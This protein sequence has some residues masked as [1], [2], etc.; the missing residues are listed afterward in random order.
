MTTAGWI[1]M[2]GSVGAVVALTVYCFARVL[3]TPTTKGHIH[4][5]LDIDH[6]EPLD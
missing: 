4:A 3:R 2:L 5:P 6:D 1:F